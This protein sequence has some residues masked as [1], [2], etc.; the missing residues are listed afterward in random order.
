M[1]V[2]N[3]HIIKTP[4]LSNTDHTSIHFLTLVYY[5]NSNYKKYRIDNLQPTILFI[6]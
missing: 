6:L 5:I 1:I 3:S 4:Q 2:N